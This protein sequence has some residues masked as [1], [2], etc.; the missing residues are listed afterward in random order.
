MSSDCQRRLDC[1]RFCQE[2]M[3][4]YA[5]LHYTEG[6]ETSITLFTAWGTSTL[7]LAPVVKHAETKTYFELDCEMKDLVY[8]NEEAKEFRVALADMWCLMNL[9]DHGNT[10]HDPQT[11]DVFMYNSST[12]TW[13][14]Y[15]LADKIAA[16]EAQD[17]ILQNAINDLSNALQ[18]LRGRVNDI[19][20]AIYNW[21]ND[22]TTKIPRGTINIFSGDWGSN[23]YIRSRD[24]QPDND[25]RFS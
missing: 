6:D 4:P 19:E 21:D 14:R 17:V 1:E 3:Q 13:E 25:L 8:T 5:E 11:G 23:A 22:K 20:A 10:E 12:Q 18:I 16:L 15:P 24:G 2:P 7:D 9:E